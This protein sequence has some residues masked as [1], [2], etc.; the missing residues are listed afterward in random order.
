MLSYRDVSAWDDMIRLSDR[1]HY[2]LKSNVLVRQQRGLALNRRNHPGDRDKAE[3]ILKSIEKEK[4]PD[5]ETLA[6]LA[7]FT[8]TNT[9]SRNMPARPG[10]S[11][12]S[13][14]QSKPTRGLSI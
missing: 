14:A 12:T 4:G 6:S 13:I 8:K 10:P 1:F 11:L 3:Q 9:K 2:A 7:A 5:P